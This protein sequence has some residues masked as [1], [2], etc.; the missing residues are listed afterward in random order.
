MDT[1]QQVTDLLFQI[2]AMATLLVPATGG[3]KGIG[4]FIL[5]KVPDLHIGPW[6][7]KDGTYLSWAG[8]LVLYLLALSRG[9][10]EVPTGWEVDPLLWGATVWAGISL[11]ANAFRNWALP[12][13]TDY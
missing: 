2:A 1:P 6:T 13:D 4:V 5:D 7:I 11:M 9:W 8:G 3:I 12:S 10:Y